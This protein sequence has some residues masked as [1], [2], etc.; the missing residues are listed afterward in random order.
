MRLPTH[1][2][3]AGA[4][5]LDPAQACQPN[6]TYFHFLSKAGLQIYGNEKAVGRAIAKSGLP[7]ES[8]L[9]TS[10]VGRTKHGYDRARAS[11]L[12]SLKGLGLEYIDL[13]L[14]H[15]PGAKTGWPLRRGELS[16]ADW[17][18]AMREETWRAL[19]DLRAEGKLRN[20][21]VSNYARHHLEQ[22]LRSC[23]IKPMVNQV[24]L[25]PLHAQTD[26][27]E[28][29]RSA[30]VLVQAFASLGGGDGAGYSPLLT[31]PVVK[32][33][34]AS[35]AKAP[36]QILLKWAVMKGLHVIPKSRSAARMKENLEI[37]DFILTEVQM[38]LLDALDMGR[39]LT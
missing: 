16:P 11:C 32:S 30:G 7:R 27:V 21:G 39:R 29:C 20:I 31:H 17:T 38:S 4:C 24:E 37:G 28:F 3:R 25:H 23:R 35:L 9:V 1:R 6:E 5:L 10:K 13:M 15:W 18:P 8:I 19:E 33:L 22:L 26:L 34:A 14:V 36:A 2:H 12:Q